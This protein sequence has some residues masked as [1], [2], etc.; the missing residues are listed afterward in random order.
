MEDGDLL[1]DFSGGT[2]ILLNRLLLRIF[3][4]PIGTLIVDASQKF[5]RVAVEHF[6]DDPRVGVRLLRY[7]RDQKRL[8]FIDEVLDAPLL[9][10][11]A[12]AIV[13]T[14]ALHLYSNLDETLRSW[15]RVVRPGGRL[16]IN[17][18]N[19]RNPDAA[20]NEWILD[21]T[22]YVVH[23]VATGIA[24]TDPRYEAYRDVLYDGPRLQRHLDFRDRVFA[25]P[26]PLALYTDALDRAGFEV[27]RVT[28]ETI[29]ADVDDWFE[30]LSAYHE[31]VLGWVGGT[32]KVDGAEPAEQAVEDRLALIRD[33]LEVIFGERPGFKC[34]WTYIEGQRRED[35]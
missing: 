26:R 2:G 4:R 33:A 27:H 20:S 10:R 35:P 28:K 6:R 16:Y 18:G 17:S 8:E 9:E 31:P 7:L 5:L 12:D 34:C 32:A 21:E 3:D 29:A 14:N 30:L 23:E 13:S 11:K 25:A 1:I 19:V 22:V 24:R 15:A